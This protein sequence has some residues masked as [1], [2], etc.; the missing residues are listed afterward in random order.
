[1]DTL[2]PVTAEPVASEELD[3]LRAG[4]ERVSQPLDRRD[5]LT[6]LVVG[7]AFL[8]AAAATALFL[9]A[10]RDFD[11][12]TAAALVALFALSTRVQLTVGQGYTVPSQLAFVPMLLLLPTPLV[13]LLVLAGWLLGKLPETLTGR[14]HPSRLLYTFANSWF[15]IGPALVLTLLDAQTPEWSHWP[16]YLLALLSQFVVDT[17]AGE[18]R[19]WIGRGVAPRVTLGLIGWVQAIDALLSPLGLLAAFAS[20]GE[21]WAFLLLFPPATLLILYAREREGR[22]ASALALA[23][24]AQRREELIAGASHEMLTPLAVL[25]GLVGRLGS[26]RP[27]DDDR[28]VEIHQAMTRE[29]ARLRQL[30]VSFVDYTRVKAG[31]PISVEPRPIDVRAVLTDLGATF[32][33]GLALVLDVPADLPRV[34]ADRDRLLQ[35]LTAIVGNAVRFAPPTAPPP[36]LV[37]RNG[38]STITIAVRDQGPGIPEHELPHVFDELFRGSTSAGT[39]GAGIGLF[40]AKLLTEAQ[41]GTITATSRP[42]AGAEFVVTLPVAGAA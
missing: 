10:D 26:R 29:V 9:E 23:E 15:A 2:P 7:G 33:P 5:R 24:A 32:A 34:H 35:V 16:V 30:A 22:L 36:S 11:P 39:D 20:E 4:W 3:L 38:G 31:R 21:R 8:V 1:V 6:E 17:V 27:L 42:G 14:S 25:R 12:A 19:E 40:L 37:V 13:P 41:G 18:V 28:R